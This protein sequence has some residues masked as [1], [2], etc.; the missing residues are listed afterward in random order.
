[1]RQNLLL[2]TLS[3]AFIRLASAQIYWPTYPTYANVFIDPAYALANNFS[4]NTDAAQKS[5]ISTA[6]E[7]ADQGPWSE[8]L[9][10][11]KPFADL[12]LMCTL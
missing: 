8:D 10:V 5:I 11:Q 1:M 7:L 12:A 2:S 6:I 3:L 4:A 9:Q